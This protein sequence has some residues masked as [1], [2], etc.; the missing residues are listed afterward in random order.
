MKRDIPWTGE[1]T[2]RLVQ[3]RRSGYSIR[4]IAAAL[5]RSFYSVRSKTARMGLPG[6]RKVGD[7]ALDA[8]LQKWSRTGMSYV[9]MSRRCGF[10]PAAIAQRCRA[11]AAQQ[12][13]V[14]A[15]EVSEEERKPSYVG[16]QEMARVI[17]PL[18][19]I[20]PISIYGQ[21]RSRR[22]VHARATIAKALHER[23]VTASQIARLLKRG[24]HTTILH[25]LQQF[26]VYCRYYATPAMAYDT[27]KRLERGEIR[28]RA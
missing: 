2:E 13:A 26:D 25:A 15:V 24:D 20:T 10:S 6:I 18:F 17:A 27:I 12:A 3:M 8:H 4:Q 5:G 7:E 16:H 28:F 23:G 11:I 19:G 21:C 14:T 1:E 9:E 22:Y